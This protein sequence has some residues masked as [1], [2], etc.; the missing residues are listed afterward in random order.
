MVTPR[1]YMNPITVSTFL[2]RVIF[3]LVVFE[4]TRSASSFNA[5]SV[6]GALN[7]GI[8]SSSLLFLLSWTKL[9]EIVAKTIDMHDK[10]MLERMYVN[11][12]GN[13]FDVIGMK[14]VKIVKLTQS[15]S[16]TVTP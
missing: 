9:T 2:N 13:V 15:D 4:Q 14:S 6:N 8:L 16:V 1:R 5:L 3:F 12:L 10:I 7:P 11:N